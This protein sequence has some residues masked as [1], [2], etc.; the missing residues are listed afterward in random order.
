[1][2]NNEERLKAFE[3]NALAPKKVE[4]DAGTVEQHSIGDQIKALEYMKKA[5]AKNSFSRMGFRKIV[6]LD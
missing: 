2:E 4:T 6:N 3:E 1:M 5:E